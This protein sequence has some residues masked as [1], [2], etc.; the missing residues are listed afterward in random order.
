MNVFVSSWLTDHLLAG[1]NFLFFIED[2]LLTHHNVSNAFNSDK[3]RPLGV[4]AGED[5]PVSPQ[6]RSLSVRS[7]HKRALYSSIALSARLLLSVSILAQNARVSS[8][9]LPY[10]LSLSLSSLSL[11]KP[12]C[13][14]RSSVSTHSYVCATIC[15]ARW[16][17]AAHGLQSRLQAYSDR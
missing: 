17:S 4:S 7:G 5:P 2:A 11:A 15:G 6:P 14:S 1:Q 3:Y 12:S 9:R 16:R 10:P 13:S 8:K